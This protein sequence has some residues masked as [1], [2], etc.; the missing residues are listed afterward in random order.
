[1]RSNKE[2]LKKKIGA[3]CVVAACSQVIK[4]RKHSFKQKKK[5]MLGKTLAG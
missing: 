1:M 2:T 5:E 4:H 3:L